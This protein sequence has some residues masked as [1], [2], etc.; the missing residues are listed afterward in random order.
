[1]LRGLVFLW[2]VFLSGLSFAVSIDD[3][4]RRVNSDINNGKPLVAHISVALADNEYQ[5][6]AKVPAAIGNG[7][8]PSNNLY[9][10][11]MYGL[12]TFLSK[13]RGWNKVS[14][15]GGIPN[16]VLER[17]VLSKQVSIG[18]KIVSMYL[19][20]DAWDGRNIA[21]TVNNTVKM[22]AGHNP[23]MIAVIVKNKHVEIAAGSNAHLVGY[24]GHNALMD[25]SFFGSNTLTA[26]PNIEKIVPIKGN[27]PKSVVIL[28]CQSK[29]YFLEKLKSIGT[30]PMILTTG[31]MAPEAYTLSAIL[32]AFLRQ[33][34]SKYVH[35]SAAKAYAKYQKS[36]IN[37]AKRLF[38]YEK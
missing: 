23:E 22:A 6:I 13:K 38:S 25:M 21:E 33:N 28:A 9:W 27:L 29:K 12:K 35:A 36:G 1:M 7:Q 3:V 26:T 20:A 10:G 30:H 4:Y 17:I 16:G 31:N 15:N 11:A 34:R 24:I 19:V 18:G 32:D 14:Y 2:F 5:W 37:G 8:D